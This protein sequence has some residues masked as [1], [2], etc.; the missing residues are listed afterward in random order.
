MQKARLEAKLKPNIITD[1]E[2]AALEA[3]AEKVQPNSG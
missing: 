2:I 3:F 1:E